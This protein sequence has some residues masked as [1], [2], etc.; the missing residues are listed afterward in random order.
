[1]TT[2]PSNPHSRPTLAQVAAKAGV[3]HQTVS[4]VIN[5]FPGVRA[6]TRQRVQAAIDELGYR[7][8]V[9]AR[10]LVTKTSR[11][12]GVIA[13]GSFHYGPTSTLSSIDNAV[14]DHGYMTLLATVKGKD[15]RGLKVA[16]ERCLEYAVDVLIV[17]ANQ[18]VWVR[19]V[20]GLDTG[21]PVILVGPQP[22]DMAEL[23]CMS[24]DQVHGAQM[25]I[26]HLGQLG[27]RS[28][29]LLAGP[30]A[31]IDAQQRLSAAVE[32]CRR[33]SIEF[34]VLPGDWTAA[35]G[36]AAGQQL[37]RRPVGDRP[38]AVFAANDQMALGLL[39]ALNRGGIS[40]PREISVIGFDDVPDARYYSPAL[41]TVRQDFETLGHRVLEQA[42]RLLAGQQVEDRTLA[43]ILKVR[44]STAPVTLNS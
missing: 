2:S 29:A 19:Y 4:R 39:S 25:A 17:I 6:A 35:S 34:E 13:I 41:T 43:P 31:W 3:S 16:V 38:T 15:E 22:S 27:H 33:R 21:V 9:A 10:A 37:V 30:S 23:T 26:D 40:V 11:L 12:V 20:G 8:N 5:G 36:F 32:Q 7:R 42:L 14:R 18:E 44:D 24:V 28:V 1:M